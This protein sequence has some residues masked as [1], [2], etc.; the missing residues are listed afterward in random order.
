[1]RTHVTPMVPLAL[2]ALAVALLAGGCTKPATEPGSQRPA[3]T[4]ISA[5]GEQMATCPVMGTTMPKSKMIPVEVNGKTVYVCCQEC[6]GKLK[7]DP[8]KYL[9]NPTPA[10]PAREPMEHGH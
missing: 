8:D 7:A 6:V 1:M 2:A 3:A 9:R 4:A 10:K 5:A